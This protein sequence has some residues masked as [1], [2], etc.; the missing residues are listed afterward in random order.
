MLE[1]LY[2][3]REDV[4]QTYFQEYIFFSITMESDSSKNIFEIDPFKK[5]DYKLYS[6]ISTESIK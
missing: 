6:H 5:Q 4:D 2:Q 3:K 1:W